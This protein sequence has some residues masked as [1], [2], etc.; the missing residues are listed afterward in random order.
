MPAIVP[1]GD[2]GVQA[3]WY[4]PTERFEIYFEA[5][6]EIAAWTENRVTG[7]EFEAEGTEA[8]QLLLD[9]AS[10]A[11]NEHTLAA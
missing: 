4:S 10:R 2:G 6:G 9:W 1:I 3:E 5:D 8:V 7:V 11:N